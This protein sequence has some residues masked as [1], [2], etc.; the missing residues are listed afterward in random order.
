MVGVGAIPGIAIDV[1]LVRTVAAP[2]NIQGVFGLS[3]PDIL[4]LQR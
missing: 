2:C 3:M 4:A 1:R